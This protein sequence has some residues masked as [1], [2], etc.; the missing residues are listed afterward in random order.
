MARSGWST[1]NYLQCAAGLVTAVPLSIAAWARDTAGSG[2]HEMVGIGNSGSASGRNTYDLYLSG[3][4]LRAYTGDGSSGDFC[5]AGAAAPTN[6]WFHAAAVFAANNSRAVYL[7]GGNKGTNAV[8]HT[9]SGINRVTIGVEAIIASPWSG[10]LAEIAI[11]NVALS[12]TEVA[13]LAAGVHPFHIQP[14]ALVCY[15]PVTGRKSPEPN[16]VDGNSFSVVG[17]LSQAAHPRIVMP[18][19]RLWRP[20]R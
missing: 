9:P 6:T 20:G 8:S 10:D 13:K 18:Q 19:K 14:Q 1:S 4:S 5:S 11:W 2:L 16:W 15:C 7:N 17:T 12:D 3:T